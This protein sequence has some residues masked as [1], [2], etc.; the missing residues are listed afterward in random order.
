MMAYERTMPAGKRFFGVVALAALVN[1]CVFAVILT[2]E[3][4]ILLDPRV[5]WLA[6]FSFLIS[7]VGLL[8]LL[9]LWGLL[10]DKAPKGKVGFLV[11][12]GA[13]G[14]LALMMFSSTEEPFL[15]ALCGLITATIFV[16]LNSGFFFFQDS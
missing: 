12:D 16:V 9:L 7:A 3:F 15:F 13:G 6:I 8:L 10:G 11:F 1:L 5:H 14:L 4:T 2:G